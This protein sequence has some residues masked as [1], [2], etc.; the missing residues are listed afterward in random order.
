M[1]AEKHK[2]HHCSAQMSWRSRRSEA[3]VIASLMT[4]LGLQSRCSLASTDFIVCNG[5][6]GLRPWRVKAREH[7]NTRSMKQL[8]RRF[9]SGLDTTGRRPKVDDRSTFGLWQ[10]GLWALTVLAR[11][12]KQHETL[13]LPDSGEVRHST[14]VPFE[15]QYKSQVWAVRPIT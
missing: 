1:C 9:D 5:A 6:K 15:R 12:D 13:P 7:G 2:G 3:E 11:Y 4:S 8:V 14:A 10:E